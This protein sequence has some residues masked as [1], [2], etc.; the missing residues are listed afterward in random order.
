M[1][2]VR[3]GNLNETISVEVGERDSG[4]EIKIERLF[5]P[6]DLGEYVSVGIVQENFTGNNI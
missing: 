5:K 6:T 1:D 2:F 3:F 4:G